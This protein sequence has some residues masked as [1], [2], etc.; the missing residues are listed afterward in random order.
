MCHMG[1]NGTLL[2]AYLCVLFYSTG[3]KENYHS[4]NICCLQSLNH[5]KCLKNVQY[6]K[7]YNHNC[8]KLIITMD[9]MDSS[10]AIYCCL[11][12]VL[13]LA[14]AH[15]YNV[16]RLHLGN[17]GMLETVVGLSLQDKADTTISSVCTCTVGSTQC[18]GCMVYSP[19]AM[20]AVRY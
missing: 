18:S 1:F 5:I 9:R 13:T 15:N 17:W 10:P 6:T 8:L 7:F 2:M 19:S 3:N 11:H 14:M 16:H 12:C 4:L 20:T